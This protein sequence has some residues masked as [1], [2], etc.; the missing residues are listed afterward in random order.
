MTIVSKSLKASAPI[1]R[2]SVSDC[3]TDFEKKSQTP[4]RFGACDSLVIRPSSSRDV[5]YGQASRVHCGTCRPSCV[6]QPRRNPER[7]GR[8]GRLV[9]QPHRLGHLSPQLWQPLW[10]LSRQLWLRPW[11]H[12]QQLWQH[13]WLH[14]RLPW[15]RPWLHLQ[16]PWQ[17]L[18]LHL[19]RLRQQLLRRLWLHPPQLWR[20]LWLH[21]Q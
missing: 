3:A 18:W 16:R 15:R 19:R 10:L 20:R 7:P 9:R 5:F 12:L 14:L 17:H 11:L 1:P 8:P 21:L 13:L 6:P 2:V 4:L